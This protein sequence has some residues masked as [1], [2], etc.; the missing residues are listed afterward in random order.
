[1]KCHTSTSAAG[2]VPT[3]VLVGFQAGVGGAYILESIKMLSA[4]IAN[5]FSNNMTSFNHLSDAQHR[6]LV[7]Y[8]MT[9]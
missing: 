9:L 2:E 3:S 1:M 7:D 6:A 4:K 5:G 8:V